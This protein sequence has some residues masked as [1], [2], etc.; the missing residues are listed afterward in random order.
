MKST[1]I[2]V[3]V[4]RLTLLVFYGF[5]SP[6]VVESQPSP[7]PIQEVSTSAPANDPTTNQEM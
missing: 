2:V 1:N 4:M 5:F 7:A 3:G 6:V